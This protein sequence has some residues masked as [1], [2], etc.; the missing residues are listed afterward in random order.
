MLSPYCMQV[1]S[2]LLLLLLLSTDAAAAP[3]LSLTLA[4]DGSYSVQVGA[5]KLAFVSLDTTLAA[6]GN[7]YS[8]KAKTLSLT[9]NV[10]SSGSDGIGAFTAFTYTWQS[11]D[12]AATPFITVFTVYSSRAAIGF[13]TQYP[14]GVP[15]QRTGTAGLLSTFPSLT[16]APG[17]PPL[18]SIFQPPASANCGWTVDASAVFPVASGGLLVV[19]PRIDA[20]APADDRVAVGFAALTQQ[21]VLRQAVQAGAAITIGPGREFDIPAGW[22]GSSLLVAS[23][24]AAADGSSSSSSSADA[25]VPP[26]GVND[27]LFT[28]GDVLLAYHGKTRPAL[29]ADRIHS[30]LGYATAAGFYFYNACDCKGVYAGSKGNGTCPPDTGNEPFRLNNCNSE[31]GL[32]ECV[33]GRDQE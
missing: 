18:G 14:A 3:A 24:I 11:N 16:A 4:S 8:A 27:A 2:L 10:T 31:R 15:N 9:K 30:S 17:C 12:A 33:R 19:T 20:S 29:N 7:V 32:R 6:N 21:P 26:G 5:S 28:L 22:S 1:L 23:Q 13:S 25:G